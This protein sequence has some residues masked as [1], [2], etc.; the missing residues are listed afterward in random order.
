MPGRGAPKTRL[1]AIPG[2]VPNPLDWPS[3]CHFRDR[4]ARADAACALAQPPLLAIEAR[5]DVA[6]FKVA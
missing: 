4:C 5:H 6:C 1:K 3:G 2:M